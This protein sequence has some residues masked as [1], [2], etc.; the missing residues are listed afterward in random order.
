MEERRDSYT[1]QY[2]QCHER[3]GCYGKLAA[4]RSQRAEGHATGINAA[5]MWFWLV[6]ELACLGRHVQSFPFRLSEAAQ[7]PPV[8]TMG[9]EPQH[10]AG[11]L[12]GSP[13]AVF[14]SFCACVRETEFKCEI[15]I[16]PSSP[17]V[18][19]LGLIW[20]NLRQPVVETAF[21]PSA[22]HSF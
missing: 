15:Q 6:E 13:V 20:F 12:V 22:T 9:E 14:T 8:I 18:F 16:S 21:A 3:D 7:R 17:R 11:R 4:Q 19:I 2:L 1:A 10:P 5:S